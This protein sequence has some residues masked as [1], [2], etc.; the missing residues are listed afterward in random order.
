MKGI[1]VIGMM[2]AICSLC[3]CSFAQETAIEFC[4]RMFQETKECPQHSCE[5]AKCDGEGC[6]A[7]A[8]APKPCSSF[9]VEQCLNEFCEVMTDCSGKKVCGDKHYDPPQCG[10][11]AYD[12]QGVLC[13]EGFVRR[14]G[15]EFFDHTCD[16]LGEY[17]VYSL[18]ICIPCGDGVCANFE[19]RCNCPED[20][21]PKGGVYQG[22]KFEREMTEAESSP[23]VP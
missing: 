22:R 2:G 11:L 20:C 7:D 12:G 1:R 16:M 23:Q 8:C 13:C 6:I 15:I 19:N 10:K 18:P 14:C 4:Q 5:V 3:C 21:H 9:S 17:S